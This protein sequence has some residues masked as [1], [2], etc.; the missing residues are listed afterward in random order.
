M[1]T[2]KFAKVCGWA[3]LIL[4]AFSLIPAF[5][6]S[7][8][9]LPV[10]RLNISDGKFLG[11]LPLNLLSK[12]LLIGFGL[13]GILVSHK[14]ESTEDASIDY[15][16]VLFY[17]MGLLAS[18][19]WFRD[20]SAFFGYMPVF[21]GAGIFYGVLSLLGFYF[22]YITHRARVHDNEPQTHAV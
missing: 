7:A 16:R 8:H 17:T 18:F 22:G 9:D 5:V 3:L 20:T 15:A 1:K 21:Y 19:S 10:L 6:G 14:K 2:R 11:Y 12:I 4:G 13:G